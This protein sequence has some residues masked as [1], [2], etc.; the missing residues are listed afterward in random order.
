MGG[1]RV[2]SKLTTDYHAFNGNNL[3]VFE[4]SS[5]TWSRSYRSRGEL[6]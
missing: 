3:K 1:I 5:S 4:L 6:E 2:Y